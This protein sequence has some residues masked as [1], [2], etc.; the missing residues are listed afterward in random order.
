MFSLVHSA[1]TQS[2]EDVTAMPA[3]LEDEEASDGAQPEVNSCDRMLPEVASTR[4]M[5]V[6]TEQFDDAGAPISSEGAP[7]TTSSIALEP[8]AAAPADDPPERRAEEALETAGAGNESSG[9]ATCGPQKSA[10]RWLE[11][12]L[13]I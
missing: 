1:T 12:E 2:S 7:V 5:S 4:G 10:V 6:R 11:R 13:Q 3:L 8:Q 9:E